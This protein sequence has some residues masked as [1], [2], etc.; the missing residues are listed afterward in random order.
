MRRALRA[1]LEAERSGDLPEAAR[2]YADAAQA[3]PADAEARCLLGNV[4]MRLGRFADAQASYEAALALRPGH[5]DALGNR[6]VALAE[7]GRLE[8]AIAG[9]RLALAVRPDYPEAHYNLGNALRAL[10]RVDGAAASYERAVALRPAWPEAHSNHGMALAALGR[11][12]AAIAA[13]ERA[14]ALRPDYPEALNGLALVRQSRGEFAEAARLFDRALALRPDFAQAHANRAQL[15]LQHGDFAQGWPE[16]EWRWKLPG[17]ALPPL[18][19]PQ[20]DGA[21]LA[22]R[23]ILLRAEQGLGDTL[24]FVRY[25]PLLARGGARVVVECQPAL[26]RLLRSCPGIDAVVARGAALPPADVQAP[27]LGL[28]G[29]LGTTADDVPADVPYLFADAGLAAPWRALI[30]PTDALRIGIAWQGNPVF[31]QDCHR[32][33]P[34]DAFAPLAALP[35]VR[36]VSLQRGFGAGQLDRAAFPVVDLGRHLEAAGGDLADTAAAMLDLDLVIT[37]CSALA[38]LAGALG[39][40]VWVPLTVSPD[41]RWLLG[42]EDTPWYPTMR[43]L[44]Q[45]ALDGWDEVFARIAAAVG[46]LV[47]A[48]QG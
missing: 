7:Q 43:L 11:T 23:T 25:A 36:L 2:R 8:A 10:R 38:H 29:L 5:P 45:R 14:L 9:Y 18:P 1:G 6:A 17:V 20:W 32:R 40:P 16:Y 46:A 24:Q 41:F 4:Q 42:R 28:P 12:D 34:L 33:I 15:R 35:G 37:V 19:V 30:G 26:A 44:R 47:A 31:P 13:Y 21:P 39:R 22:G 27:L 48:Q 3:D